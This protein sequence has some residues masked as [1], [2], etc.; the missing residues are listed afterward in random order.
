MKEEKKV[1]RALTR[2]CG[3]KKIKEIRIPNM[4]EVMEK[5]VNYIYLGYKEGKHW[6]KEVNLY[7]IPL[8]MYYRP[9]YGC[10]KHPQECYEIDREKWQAAE[11]QLKEY[12]I[13]ELDKLYFFI[14][15]Y[16][17]NAVGQQ[18]TGELINN[19]VRIV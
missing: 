9:D 19:K 17:E 13:E 3:N 1:K 14:S 4:E 16:G 7:E 15:R 11:S 8:E 12:K 5:K 10:Q 18:F 2:S 6:C